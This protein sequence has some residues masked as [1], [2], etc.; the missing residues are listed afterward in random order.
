MKKTF[1]P[2]DPRPFAPWCKPA[3]GGDQTEKERKLMERKTH[4]RMEIVE[5]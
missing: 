5:T 3:L 1:G 2:W 4:I